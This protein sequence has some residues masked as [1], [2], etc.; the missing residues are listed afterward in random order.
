MP[1]ETYPESSEQGMADAVAAF[2]KDEVP[3][4]IPTPAP[5]PPPQVPTPEEEP[6]LEEPPDEEAKDKV[7]AEKTEPEEMEEEFVQFE[8]KQKVRFNKVY[9][10]LQNTLRANAELEERIQQ[11]QRYQQQPQPVVPQ[12][13]QPGFYQPAPPEAK[14]LLANFE[15]ADQWADAVADWSVRKAGAAAMSE[16]ASQLSRQTQD[17]MVQDY[18]NHINGKIAEG[19]KK[20]GVQQFNDASKDI[21]QFAPHGSPLYN[22]LVELERFPEVVIH[23]SKNL[24]LANHISSL[25]QRDLIYELKSL[26]RKLALAA[27]IPP[28][29]PTKVEAPG[30]GDEPAK[31]SAGLQKLRAAAKASGAVKDFAKLFQADP[32]L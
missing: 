31:P 3:A 22:E 32:T 13:Q 27:K 1:E 18:N 30:N 24:E 6:P 2:A 19:Q 25:S 5:T 8:G 28:K 4:P 23:L 20:F 15:T 14:P 21:V 10:K 7:A 26:E 12:P 9:G 17:R 29:L 11:L 16:L